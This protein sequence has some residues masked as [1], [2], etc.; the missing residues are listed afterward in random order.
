[1]GRRLG[2]GEAQ[3]R[4]LRPAALHDR[5]PEAPVQA[6]LQR[7]DADLPVALHSVAVSG[8]EQRPGHVHGQ[9][10]RERA[11]RRY[12]FRACDRFRR[13]RARA[14]R[15]Q[16][17]RLHIAVKADERRHRIAGQREH[18]FVRGRDAEPHRFARLLRHLVK[19]HRDAEARE[20][21]G[22]KIEFP[23]RNAAAQ[24]EPV[25][26]RQQVAERPFN[27]RR[28]IRQTRQLHLRAAESLQRRAQ[29]PRIRWPNLE[30]FDRRP[31]VDD[32]I[33]YRNH[34]E[35]RR[36]RDPHLR[37]PGGHR[38]GDLGRTQPHPGGQQHLA[39]LAIHALPVQKLAA[40]DRRME[41][42]P[43]ALNCHILVGHN[44]IRARGTQRPGHD[45][46][47]S[48][49]RVGEA[50]RRLARRLDAFHPEHRTPGR[51]RDRDAVHRGAIKRRQIAVGPQVLPQYAPR[52]QREHHVLHGPQH[53]PRQ[54]PR[55]RL[56]DR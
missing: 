23:A 25:A 48:V 7:I 6:H 53:G 17:E 1:M 45:F 46:N 42:R 51:M 35:P 32:F 26:P 12:G 18:R 4:I 52:R 38:D 15:L 2:A 56:R 19:R 10:E 54:Y 39:R 3:D 30:S 44:R 41:G 21:I 37:E 13:R 34:P 5:E 9:E 27:L 31:R 40:L 55:L 16:D 20:D 50:S 43:P 24:Q 29:S 49:F 14:E 28:I 47:T 8:R 11:V 36:S 33:A 22:N